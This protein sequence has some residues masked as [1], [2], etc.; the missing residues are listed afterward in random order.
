MQTLVVAQQPPLARSAVLIVDDEPDIRDTLKDLLESILG[1]PVRTAASGALALEMLR[2]PDPAFGLILSDLRMPG[3]DGLEF[4][5]QAGR[6]APGVARYVV[7]AY[8]DG[9]VQA[10]GMPVLHKPFDIEQL[11]GVVRTALGLAPAS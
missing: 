3:M 6:L 11:L 8:E 7:T 4:L 10:Q 2:R 9:G 1:I 5:A